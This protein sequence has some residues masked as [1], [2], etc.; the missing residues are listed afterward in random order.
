MDKIMRMHTV[1]STI[2][3]GF[4]LLP[5]EAPWLYD[6]Y[7]EIIAFPVCKHDDQAD[8]TSQALDWAKQTYV[9]YP[10]FDYR[11]QQELRE[12]LG[13]GGDYRFIEWDDGGPKLVRSLGY[14]CHHQRNLKTMRGAKSNALLLRRANCNL[15]Y[16]CVALVNCPKSWTVLP[17]PS[18]LR[19]QICGFHDLT[20]LSRKRD[21]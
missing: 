18:R 16:P 13:L 4:V 17:A 12:R 14:E 1:T 20:L 11:R 8:A 7:K 10:V 9:R 2:E 6:Y 19:R 15:A 21:R 5:T 3:N